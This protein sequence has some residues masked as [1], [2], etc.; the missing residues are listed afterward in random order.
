MKHLIFRIVYYFL[1]E[2]TRI[3]NYLILIWLMIDLKYLSF[4]KYIAQKF[5]NRLRMGTSIRH[6]QFRD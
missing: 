5:V 3:K 2:I 6:Y 4:L 1:Q